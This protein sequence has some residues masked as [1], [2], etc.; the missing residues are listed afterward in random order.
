MSS[1]IDNILVYV[2]GD[3]EEDGIIFRGERV[4]VP[5]S[6]RQDML[7]KIH[8]SHIGNKGC[9]RRARDVLAWHEC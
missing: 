5:D 6:M 8:R 2:D 7:R 9:L 1:V 4:V 3:T